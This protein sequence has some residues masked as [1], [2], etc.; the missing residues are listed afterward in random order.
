MKNS[1]KIFAAI[2]ALIFAVFNVL[3][4]LPLTQPSVVALDSENQTKMFI[5]SY[6]FVV[7]AF[8]GVLICGISAFKQNKASG[9]FLRLPVIYWSYSGLVFMCIAAVVIFRKFILLPYWVASAVGLVILL[10]TAVSVILASTAA[11]II[12]GIDN[13][14]KAQTMFI[15]SMS[16]EAETISSRA[17]T[18][19]MSA[20]CK[21]VYEAI[22]YSDPMSDPALGM[23]ES[24]I[25]KQFEVFAQSVKDNDVELAR[26]NATELIALLDSRNARCKLLK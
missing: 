9:L 20:E 3:V 4:L 10:I 19:E 5:V 12:E 24:D 23:I 8:V 11:D 2:W 1:I 13:K 26:A 25:Y 17:Q 16:V 6:L 7:L 21:R 15:K 14:V 18:S 22:R